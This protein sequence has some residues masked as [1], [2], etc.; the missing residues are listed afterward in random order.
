VYLDA[1]REV[2]NSQ[3]LDFQRRAAEQLL[4]GGHLDEGRNVIQNVLRPFGLYLAKGPKRALVSFLLRRLHL[5]LRGLK[6]DERDASEIPSDQLLQIDICWAVAVGLSMVDS[7]RSTD[8]QTRHLL[9]ALRAG[10]PYR[11]A[12]AMAMEAGFSALAG[13]P[14]I[15]RASRFLA[16]A[17]NLSKKVDHPHAVALT[18]LL[19]GVCAFLVG[20]WRKAANLSEDARGIFR[21][22]CRVVWEQTSAD[23]FLLGSLMYLGEYAEISDS[24]AA[25]LASAQERGNLYASTELRTRMNCVWLARDEPE[26][27]RMELAE[28]MQS[29]SHEGFHRQHY[30]WLLAQANIELYN[31]NGPAAYQLVDAKW[32]ELRRSLLLRI[33]VLRLEAF[34]LKART[35]LA[36]S[37]ADRQLQVAE[38]LATRI[39]REKMHWSDP[40]ALLIH[41]GIAN[42][43][44]QTD[45]ARALLREAAGR[46]ETAE[47]NYFAA[48]ARRQ[49]GSLSGSGEGIRLVREA[50]AWMTEH[51]IRNPARFT[52]MWSPGFPSGME[53]KSRSVWTGRQGKT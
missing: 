13:G 19:G 47:M 46:F 8:F 32:Q 21:E 35:I 30:N 38:A 53:T 22:K 18:T 31:G 45:K 51:G 24:F 9:L 27:A 42:L 49:L 28:A 10:E 5:W 6:F 12:R 20:E 41:S 1:A 34:F 52:N 14:G 3:A 7:I 33:Q 37:E 15:K 2:D 36:S 43:R 29:W 26:K 23:S 40:L 50:D 11:L 17:Q 16:Q 25:M 44:G 48:A 39:A 4:M